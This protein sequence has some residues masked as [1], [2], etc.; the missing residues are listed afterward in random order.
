MDCYAGFASLWIP[1]KA[2][3]ESIG[4]ITGCGGRFDR[5]ETE[6][7]LKEKYLKLA[8]ELEISDKD[9]FLK[10]AINEISPVTETEIR[11]RTERL[12]KLVG[13]LTERNGLEEVSKVG[14]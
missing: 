6:E 4:S 1:I 9:D 5:E 3:G 12:A 7:K 13:I 11:K 8:D 14:D 2:K 10:A